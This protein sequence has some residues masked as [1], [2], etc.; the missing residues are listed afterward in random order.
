MLVRCGRLD[1]SVQFSGGAGACGILDEDVT[2]KYTLMVFRRVEDG[3]LRTN[4]LVVAFGEGSD[5]ANISSLRQRVLD[6]VQPG[7]LPK[8]GE[9]FF[10]LIVAATTISGA[11]LLIMGKI[12]RKIAG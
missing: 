2:G 7:L 12:I 3:S 9:P 4:R 8:T 11:G 6:I 10:D 5:A 1:G